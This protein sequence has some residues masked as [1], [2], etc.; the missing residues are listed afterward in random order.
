MSQ[1]LLIQTIIT[2]EKTG[3][4]WFASGDFEVV[5]K[6]GQIKHATLNTEEKYTNQLQTYAQMV[7]LDRQ[8]IINDDLGAFEALP[9]GMGRKAN[10]RLEKAVFET[11]LGNANSFLTTANS[12]QITGSVTAL[13]ADSL[14]MAEQ[15]FLNRVDQNGDPIL[16]QPTMLLVPP[17]LSVTAAQLV[18]DT[19]VVAVGVGSS[20]DTTRA[21]PHSGKFE[22]IVSPY[23]E[24]SNITNNS[25]TGWYLMA[26][27]QA[28]AGLL[29]VGFLNGAQT[30][31]IED[32][33]LSFD[34]LGMSL[35][36]LG[37]RRGTTGPSI[38]CFCHGRGN[39][40]RPLLQEPRPCCQPPFR[41]LVG[42]LAFLMGPCFGLLVRYHRHHRRS[43]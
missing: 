23:L 16:L 35:R 9:Q 4:H 17:A 14:T 36:V 3:K 11:L 19:Q 24:N 38:R 27:P 40:V 22:P 30:P 43:R 41:W 29:E 1:C 42:A 39:L 34:T 20:A 33:E 32:G 10:L 8:S 13:S 26:A 21:N 15:L 25:V 6:G 31:T 37:L 2:Q 12:S 18:R 7:N 5:G 28:S